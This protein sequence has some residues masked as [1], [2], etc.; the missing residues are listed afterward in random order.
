MKCKCGR[1]LI[2]PSEVRA[3]KCAKCGGGKGCGSVPAG[4]KPNLFDL[5]PWSKRY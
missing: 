1:N 3:K 4:I 2:S 5:L